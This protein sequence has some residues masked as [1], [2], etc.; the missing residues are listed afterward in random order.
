MP[1]SLI[2]FI[3][4]YDNE[5]Q[6]LQTFIENLQKIEDV[7]KFRLPNWPDGIDTIKINMGNKKFSIPQ[8]KRGLRIDSPFKELVSLTQAKGQLEIQVRK[9]GI[10]CISNVVFEK[11]NFGIVEPTFVFVVLSDSDSS[12]ERMQCFVIF[13]QFLGEIYKNIIKLLTQDLEDI[14]KDIKSNQA[15]A[16]AVKKSFEPLIPFVVA[17]ILNEERP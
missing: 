8:L 6:R 10:I 13:H 12:L 9:A 2:N 5:I 11:N 3:K 4:I 7:P 16:Q 17:D 15:L 14:N 1:E